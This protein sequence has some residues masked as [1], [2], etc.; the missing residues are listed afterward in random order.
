MLASSRSAGTTRWTPTR[1]AYA[2]GAGCFDT[3]VC[4]HYR[5]FPLLDPDIAPL[6]ALGVKVVEPEVMA[7]FTPEPGQPRLQH[8]AGA[9]KPTSGLKN[10]MS[11]TEDEARKV[12][13]LARI[14]V[15]IQSSRAG[16]EL[17]NILHFCGTAERG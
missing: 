2:A 14:A 8:L 12:A 4:S 7:P 1:A 17:N 6:K 16:G 3:I 11:I 9:A 13:H 10:S 15:E 5:T